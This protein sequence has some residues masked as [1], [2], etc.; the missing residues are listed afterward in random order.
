MKRKERNFNNIMRDAIAT[1]Q[2]PEACASNLEQNI[3]SHKPEK[4]T[5][6]DEQGN[7]TTLDLIWVVRAY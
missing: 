4:V 3:K 5:V 2:D 6:V 7:A 1:L